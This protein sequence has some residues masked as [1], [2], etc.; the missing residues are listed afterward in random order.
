MKR[1]STPRGLRW[2]HDRVRS[3]RSQ[4]HILQQLPADAGDYLTGQQ[5]AEQLGISRHGLQALFRIGLLHNAQNIDFAP[6][7]I[8]RA[9]IDSQP[10]REAVSAMKA[11]RTLPKNWGCPDDQPQLFPMISTVQE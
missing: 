2:T 7:R 6:W 11:N 10:V 3:F 1:L 4:H 5:A 9:E 8:P